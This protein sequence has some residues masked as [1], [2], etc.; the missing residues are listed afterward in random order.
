MT[1]WPLQA[2]STSGSAAFMQLCQPWV[3]KLLLGAGSLTAL[4]THMR[5]IP[6]LPTLQHLP[7]RHLEVVISSRE[8]WLDGFFSDVS[9]CC[10]LESLRIVYNGARECPYIVVEAMELLDMHL[11]SMPS[12][13]RVRLD[14]CFSWHELALPA[15]A[16]LFLDSLRVCYL[17]WQE[18]CW[19]RFQHHTTILRLGFSDDE[20]WPLGIQ[21]FSHLQYL[22]LNTEWVHG[23][24]VADLQHVPHVRIIMEYDSDLQVTAGSWKTLEVLAFGELHVS[25]NDMDSF[26]RDT[27]DFTFMSESP[28]KALD[29]QMLQTQDA[30][31]RQGRVCHVCMHYNKYRGKDGLFLDKRANYVTLSTNKEVAEDFA[32]I[33]KD[34]RGRPKVSFSKSLADWQNFWPCDPCDSVRALGPMH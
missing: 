7:L 6:R 19:G 12:L 20:H 32:V 21:S 31:L 23:E 13:K 18:V 14:N 10:T 15:G 8:E 1:R 4:S 17:R 30:C 22:E 2:L 5:T 26:V 29:V 3:R 25:M 28:H 27:R 16:S 24:D 9:R 11:H 34:H 33:F